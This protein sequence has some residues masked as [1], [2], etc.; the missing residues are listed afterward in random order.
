MKKIKKMLIIICL[1]IICIFTIN[2]IYLQSLATSDNYD[3]NQF[4][5]GSSGA[6]TEGVKSTVNKTAGTI[7]AVAR[8]I[9]M[10]IAIVIILVIA[11]KYMISA[12]GDRADIKKHAINYVIGAF[13]LF[14][15]TGILGII[16]SFADEFSRT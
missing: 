14:S 12:P 16:S 2:S 4:E 6:G 9:C 15:V 11:M 10:T 3:F 8:V 7:I 5:R 13:I 1:L